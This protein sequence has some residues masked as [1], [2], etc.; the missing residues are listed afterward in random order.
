M[1]RTFSYKLLIFFL[2]CVSFFSYSAVLYFSET[3]EKEPSGSLAAEGKLIWQQKNC[4]ACHQLYGLGGHLGPDLTN[5]YSTRSEAYIR[6][7]LKNGS[8][9]MPDFKLSDQE[10]KALTAFFKYTNST[11]TAS[12]RSFSK[13]S[14]GTI[15]QP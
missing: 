11:G 14:D 4:S 5:V 9:V 1:R 2:L 8:P 15:S 10:M 12:P 7:F 13:H 6:A 3:P